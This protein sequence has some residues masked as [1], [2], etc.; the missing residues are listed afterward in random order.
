MDILIGDEVLIEPRREVKTACAL[1]RNYV[2][3][4]LKPSHSKKQLERL[5]REM[6]SCKY[7]VEFGQYE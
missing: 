3:M 4:K 6:G 7:L 2:V 1:T 5:K